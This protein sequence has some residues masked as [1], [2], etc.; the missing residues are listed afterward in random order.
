MRLRRDGHDPGYMKPVSG[1]P[2]AVGNELIDLDA[3]F[4]RETFGLD[5]E[6]ERLVP[7]QLADSL[8][9]Q[10]LERLARD[11]GD[12]RVVPLERIKSAHGALVDGHDVLLLEGAGNLAEGGL[13][14]LSGA[15][16]AKELDLPTLVVTPYDGRLTGDRLLTARRVLGGQMIGGVIN[17]APERQVELLRER[18][19]PL[20][21]ARGVPVFGVVPHRRLLGGATVQELADQIDAELLVGE[22]YADRLVETLC[23]GAMGIDDVLAHFRRKRRKAVIVEGARTSIQLAA[24][25]TST[26]CLILTGNLKP[27]ATILN[28][29][30]EREVPVVLSALSTIETVEAINNVFGKTR[31][32]EPEKLELLR[33][34]LDAAVDFEALYEAL[35]VG[36]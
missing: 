13:L 12:A 29:A 16:L 31:F 21:E 9:D 25:E 11:D 27:K 23:I 26:R 18:A 7:V 3:A 5:E 28:K 35:G 20:L 30:E 19:V 4:I 14:G 10:E 36:T 32:H 2:R 33:E 15:A 6:M 34:T 1:S 22:A 8:V 17:G 24:L